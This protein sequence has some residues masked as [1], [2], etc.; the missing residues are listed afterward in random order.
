[1]KVML[2]STIHIL[3]NGTGKTEKPNEIPSPGK[4]PEIIP[5][6]EPTPNIWPRR[7]PEI[8]P[9]KEPLTTPATTPPEVPSPSGISEDVN[10]A[11]I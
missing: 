9:G 4:N 3:N 2:K 7:M 6:E 5:S 10:N 1:M 8:Q 11:F